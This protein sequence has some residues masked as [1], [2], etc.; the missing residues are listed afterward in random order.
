MTKVEEKS[1]KIVNLGISYSEGEQKLVIC[2]NFNLELFPG[3]IYGIL[4]PNGSGKSSLL[5]ALLGQI[6][7]SGEIIYNGFELTKPLISYVPQDFTKSFFNW[8]SVRN[9]IRFNLPSLRQNWV[10][11]EKFIEDKKIELGINFDL[12]IKPMKCSGGMLQQAAIL[13]A[14]STNQGIIFGDE[15]FSALDVQIKRKLR[16]NFRN[17]IKNSNSICLLILHNMEDIVHTCDELIVIK[18]K[19]YSNNPNEIING[20]NEIKVIPNQLISKS[21]IEE[22]SLVDIATKLLMS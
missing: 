20:F 11:L 8:T 17:Y 19:P 6:E 7:Y 2:K 1:I 13:R 9:N 12:R 21:E 4:G 15:P 22:E 16:T 3:R 14:V 18:D 10:N 5:K